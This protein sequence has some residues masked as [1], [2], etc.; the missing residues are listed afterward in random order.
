MPS[1]NDRLT[2]GQYKL[3]AWLQQAA[4]LDVGGMIRA[5]GVRK[6]RDLTREQASDIIATARL[7]ELALDEEPERFRDPAVPSEAVL[8][9]ARGEQRKQKDD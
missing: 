7:V 9:W 4:G 2:E 8:R 5:L 6:A 1:P 3:L